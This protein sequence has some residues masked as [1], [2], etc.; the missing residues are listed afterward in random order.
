MCNERGALSLEQKGHG[1]EAA[2]RQL[3]VT[4]FLEAL[5][6]KA[7]SPVVLK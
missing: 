3:Q 7:A 5:D 6:F 2:E 4:E 1:E